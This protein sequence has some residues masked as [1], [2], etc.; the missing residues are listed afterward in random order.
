M[1]KKKLTAPLITLLTLPYLIYFLPEFLNSSYFNVTFFLDILFI[2]ILIDVI[3]NKF[4][5]VF[6]LNWIPKFTLWASFFFIF[7]GFIL[8][9]K[10]QTI[11][12]SQLTFL[13]RGRFISTIGFIILI[14]WAIKTKPNNYLI[15]NIFLLILNIVIIINTT[16]FFI[17][18]PDQELSIYTSKNSL[19][20]KIAKKSKPI[21]LII[22]DEY[23]SPRELF[24]VH[25]DSA[26]FEF[27]KFLKKNNWAVK[28]ISF[29]YE[30]STLHS[31]ASLF[32]YNLSKHDDYSSLSTY[33][34]SKYL[35][36]SKLFIELKANNIKVINLGIFE[37]NKIKP[38]TRLYFYPQNIFELIFQYSIIY[39]VINNT[40]LSLEGLN[41]NYYPMAIHN[42]WLIENLVDSLNK[43]KAPAFIY[44]HFYMPHAPTHYFDE[45]TPSGN[46][47]T[48]NYIKYWKFTNK[49]IKPILEKLGSNYRIILTGDHGF[50][51]KNKINPHNTFSAFLGFSEFE[52]KY[53]NSVQDY[54]NL[55]R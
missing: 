55:I 44:A 15:A 52:L 4:I 48:L 10:I 38:L 11:T 33:N 54:G 39:N 14:G 34:T 2:L 29:S 31:L 25:K 24:K 19:K 30:I 6:K 23:S 47:S 51:T 22:L 17:Q 35:N 20:P 21:L 37:I 53:I 50:R 43:I 28:E 3:L 16:I 8:T 46:N 9:E 13:I 49:K 1:L 7:Y 36:N 27:S 45:F 32:N 26:L 12:A 42:K 5:T 41:S 18:Q 40:N